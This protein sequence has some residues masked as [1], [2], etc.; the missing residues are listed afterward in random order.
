[1][2]INLLHLPLFKFA[3][4]FFLSFLSFPLNIFVNFIFI[5]LFPN[6]H[7]H[8]VLFSSL[9]FSYFCS[10]RYNFMFPLFARS[11]YFCLSIYFCWTVLILFM[12]VYVYVYIQSH[13]QLLLETSA[14]T[15]GFCRSVA[16][17]FFFPSIFSFLPF[18]ILI[19]KILLFFYIY[20]FVCFSYCPFPL[21]INF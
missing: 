17:S 20:T 19:F 15:L 1:M 9:C 21:A 16:F 12:D 4:L 18:I 2:Y 13:F 6:W 10:G 8:L 5:T 14:S 3:Y 7:L 11:I